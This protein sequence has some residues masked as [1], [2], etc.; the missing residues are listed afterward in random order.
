VPERRTEIM[1]PHDGKPDDPTAMPEEELDFPYPPED[2]PKLPPYLT[3]DELQQNDDY[4]WCL[5]DPEVQRAYG[6]Q[7]VVAHK[8]RILAVGANHQIAVE[9]A[10][11]DPNCPPRWQL[12]VVVVP[13]FMS[14]CGPR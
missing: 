2:L 7:I 13:P 14:D 6:G 9:N 5:H 10:R 11:Q 4:E 12:A 1:N 3:E 8:R